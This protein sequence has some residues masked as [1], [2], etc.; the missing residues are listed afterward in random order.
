MAIFGRPSTSGSRN[1][2]AK[3]F[4]RLRLECLETRNVLSAIGLPP[5]PPVAP[6]P[7]TPVPAEFYRIAE[8]RVD[9][10]AMQDVALML[11]ANPTR[12]QGDEATT[13]DSMDAGTVPPSL[14][15]PKYDRLP[16]HDMAGERSDSVPLTIHVQPELRLPGEVAPDNP[17]T[18]ALAVSREISEVAP[19]VPD[20]AAL[21]VSREMNE[22]AP[23][24]P[25]AADL[26][27]SRGIGKV[28]PDAPVIAALTVSRGMNDV[29][30]AAP[31]AADLA[32]SHGISEVAP[33]GLDAV[34]LA[35]LPHEFI[36][37]DVIIETLP[38][39]HGPADIRGPLS[40]PADQA[41]QLIIAN[42]VA[43]GVESFA[44]LVKDPIAD[45]PAAN[46]TSRVRDQAAFAAVETSLP[47]SNS[48]ANPSPTKPAFSDITTQNSTEG[49]FIILGDASATTPRPGN[50]PT[51]TS[52]SQ[53]T[54]GVELNRDNWLTDVLPKTQTPSDSGK[55]SSS[56]T[57]RA[58]ENLAGEVSSRPAPVILPLI[59]ESE[60]GGGI[61]LAM[62]ATSPTAAGG[63]SQLAWEP[64]ASDSA[65]QLSA[66]RPESG[67]AIFCDIEV[68]SAPN[69]PVGGSASIAIPYRDVGSLVGGVGIHGG[70]ANA[71]TESAPSLSQLQ[72]TLAGLGDHLPMLLGAATILVSQGG[73]QLEEKVSERN[74]RLRSI[75]EMRRSSLR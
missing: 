5:V 70:K 59:A 61:E 53:G 65:Q 17:D 43:S 71:T 30:P 35:A 52:G 41:I 27:V 74:R 46:T 73:L 54:E 36:K 38:V 37:F 26:A 55:H 34:D 9:Q 25:D 62:A 21:A 45:R 22:V 68:A 44:P 10:V 33:N 6:P 47:A 51:Q 29:A 4:T 11:S 13:T 75:E 2:H 50:A 18:A 14:E 64:N 39:N 48:D 32:A 42:D 20:A 60:E 1:M 49:G 7:P 40:R 67:V 8:H 56:K 63:D 23:A 24:V 69:L 31:V 12:L 3:S 72:P 66:I 58:S 16:A 28:A 57:A 15:M 19:S